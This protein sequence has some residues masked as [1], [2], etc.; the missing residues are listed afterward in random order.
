MTE[1]GSQINIKE[2]GNEYQMDI[3]QYTDVIKLNEISDKKI[4]VTVIEDEKVNEL[5][6]ITYKHYTLS[7]R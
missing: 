1:F 4:S 7:G 5:T 3:G 2:R 6:K